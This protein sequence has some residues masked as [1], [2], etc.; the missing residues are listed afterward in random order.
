MVVLWFW[1]SFEM[2]RKR[3]E[4]IVETKPSQTQILFCVTEQH[5]QRHRFSTV[6]SSIIYHHIMYIYECMHVMYWI[7]A[8]LNWTGTTRQSD[9]LVNGNV[10]VVHSGFQCTSCLICFVYSYFVRT[11]PLCISHTSSRCI[12]CII[13]YICCRLLYHCGHM[14]RSWD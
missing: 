13:H 1:S 7:H 8:S 4:K 12:V 2:L 10:M 9:N 6:I 11:M 5:R 3:M 14:N